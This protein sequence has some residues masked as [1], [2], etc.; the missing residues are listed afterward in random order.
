MAIAR[1]TKKK[2]VTK[3]P[4]AKQ[5][6]K[7]PGAARKTTAW[8]KTAGDSSIKFYRRIGSKG[9]R[10]SDYFTYSSSSP[11]FRLWLARELGTRPARILS[12][13]CG[14]GE[15]EGSLAAYG[16][17][18]FGMDLSHPMLLRAA[19]NGVDFPIEGDAR[20]L[21]FAPASF[22]VVIYP[23]SIGHLVLAEAFA[24]ARRVLRPRG[25]VIVTTY[26]SHMGAHPRFKRYRFDQME[27]ALTNTG[28]D[29]DEQRFLAAK[30]NSIA[31]ADSDAKSTL[32]YVK[33]RAAAAK[34]P[35]AKSKLTKNKR[36]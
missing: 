21:P 12:I 34:R 32:L 30:R 16:H 9:W 23:E 10:Q 19:R 15:L 33:A 3:R 13:G 4:S 22:D 36:A 27:E 7:T 29:V 1:K 31:D 2:K 26:A 25:R 8:E 24:E 35:V 5:V 14:N 18:L 6:A 28:F 11:A 17:R 20:Y